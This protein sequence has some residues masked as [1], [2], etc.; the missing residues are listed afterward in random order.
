MPRIPPVSFDRQPMRGK[1]RTAPFPCLFLSLFVFG[2]PTVNAVDDPNASAAEPTPTLTT[3][4]TYDAAAI[5]D[6]SGGLRRAA[7][8]IGNL[9]WQSLVDLDQAFGWNDSRFY[10]DLLWIHGGNPDS[11]VGD[12]MGVSNIAAPSGVQPE[13]LWIEH[14]ITAAD[15]SLLI[16]LYD[17]NSEFYRVDS[18]GLFLNSSFGIGPD[19]GLSGIEGPS[20]FPRTS[21]GARFGWKPAEGVVVRAALLDGVPLIRP[22]GAYRVFEDGDGL[23]AAA[24]LALLDRPANSAQSTPRSRLGRNAMLPPYDGKLAVGA[25]HYTTTL[26]RFD[27][28][29]GSTQH[30]TSGAYLI[31]DRIVARAAADPNR[32]VSLFVQLGTADDRVNRFGTYLG[33]GVVVSGPMRTR[34]N[35]E[36]GFAVAMA[37]N[38]SAYLRQQRSLAP[39]SRAESTL[40][41]SYLVQ[42]TSWLAIQPDIQYVIRP[43]TESSIPNALVFTLRFEV[44]RQF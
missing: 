12:A 27:D 4:L 30:G 43:N 11:F 39:A 25:W 14:N 44:A 1:G 23:L 16:G 8:Y 33:A 5:G 31:G 9:H 21:A 2:T 19:F 36:I 20:I 7:T 41:L 32:N 29:A 24:E 18:A 35:D 10:A 3:T 40:E 26:G 13:E 17:L 42:A 15:V 6:A 37:R 22:D 28:G 34:Q 38:G